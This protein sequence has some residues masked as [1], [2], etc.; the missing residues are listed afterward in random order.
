LKILHLLLSEPD[1]IVSD[2]IA[3]I[4]GSS[5]ATVVSLYP[6]D[7]AQVPINWNRVLDDIMSHEQ[8]ICWW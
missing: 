8:S 6:D 4:S 3:S 5:G 2:L 1:E 7:I